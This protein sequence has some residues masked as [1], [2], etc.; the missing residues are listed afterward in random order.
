MGHGECVDA[1]DFDAMYI[2]PDTGLPVVIAD[3]C[4]GCGACVKACPK[5]ILELRN[6]GKKDRRIFVSC[7]NEDKGGVAKKACSVA[8]IGCMKCFKVC[9]FEAITMK[10]NLAYIDYN[11][12]KLCRKCVVVCPTDAIHELNFPPRKPATPVKETVAKEIP[13]VCVIY[14]IFQILIWLRIISKIGGKK[15]FCQSKFYEVCIDE[16]LPLNSMS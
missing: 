15:I 1:C 2:D 10:N 9:P 8:C 3:K 16:M 5:D 4:V 13:K 14:S 12:C 6:K 11:K 7:V